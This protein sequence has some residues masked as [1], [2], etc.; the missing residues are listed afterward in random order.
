MSDSDFGD[1]A[2]FGLYIEDV[3]EHN[4]ATEA[5]SVFPT[6]ANGRT[7]VIIKVRNSGFLDYEQEER[8]IF[9]FNIVATQNGLQT[10]CQITLHLTDASKCFAKYLK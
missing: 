10:M 6:V 7:P 3:D 8:R 2:K 9:V 1:N 5:F 4:K